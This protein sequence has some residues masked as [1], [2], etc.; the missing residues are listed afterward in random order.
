[1]KRF[2]RSKNLQ[3]KATRVRIKSLQVVTNRRAE[4]V[5]TVKQPTLTR[6]NDFRKTKGKV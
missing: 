1:V 4:T 2:A 5:I 3:E 6:R